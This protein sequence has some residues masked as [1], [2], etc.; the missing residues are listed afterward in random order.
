MALSRAAAAAARKAAKNRGLQG[1]RGADGS[2]VRNEEFIAPEMIAK[3]VK[4]L[5]AEEISYKESLEGLTPD[6]F[7]NEINRLDSRIADAELEGD[8]ASVARL[9]RQ[10][11]IAWE[12][13][14]D[15]FEMLTKPK[16]G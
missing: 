8:V 7:V 16:E 15:A 9:E 6:E 14:D 10:S 5:T 3:E 11:E 4:P 12:M 13:Y 2:L 1:N